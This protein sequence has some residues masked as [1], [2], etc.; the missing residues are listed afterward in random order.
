MYLLVMRTRL[1]YLSCGERR[2][3][4]TTTDRFMPEDTTLPCK[5]CT[6][7]TTTVLRLKLLR[8]EEDDCNWLPL[9]ARVAFIVLLLAAATA[10]AVP[11]SPPA[12][13]AALLGDTSWCG[14]LKN[15]SGST[16]QVLDVTI[17]SDIQTGHWRLHKLTVP[18]FNVCACPPD[19]ADS[20][21]IDCHTRTA[22][23]K[24]GLISLG[25]QLAVYPRG[26]TW[27]L[28]AAMSS[29]ADDSMSR[30][31]HAA[32]NTEALIADLEDMVLDPT[33]DQ[34]CRCVRTCPHMCGQQVS[35]QSAHR[36]TVTMP[37]C[38]VNPK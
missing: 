14:P 3:T 26:Y 1:K 22:T 13:N 10:A 6:A 12:A 21:F 2:S 38:K 33:M 27:P 35:T 28:P 37:T 34:C 4:A 17:G 5:S 25:A 20:T 18:M 24:S 7:R 8:D 32:N 23:R 15:N 31:H 11:A 9:K 30:V 19:R 36:P 29:N 16:R